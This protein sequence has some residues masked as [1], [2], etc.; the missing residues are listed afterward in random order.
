MTGKTVSPSPLPPP[1]KVIST[2]SG[3]GGSSLGY[4]LA[5]CKVLVACEFVELAAKNYRLN[6]PDTNVVE[7]DIRQVSGDF[8]MK[9]GG[10]VRGELDI[11]D[12]SPP[13]DCFSVSGKRQESWGKFHNYANRKRYAQRTDNLIDE[14]IRLV[15]EIYPKTFVIENV[16]GLTM[17]VSKSLLTWYVNSLRKLG[18]DVQ[19]ELLRASY[20]DTATSRIRLFLIG[21]R[22]DLGIKASHPK[23]QTREKTI[24]EV[25]P[26]VSNT[27]EQLEEA[28]F[29]LMRS[30]R[31]GKIASRLKQGQ[32]GDDVHPSGTSWFNISR[33]SMTKPMTTLTTS[34]HNLIHPIESRSFTIP[35]LQALSS[36][37]PDF[38]FLGTYYEQNERIANAVPPNLMKAIALHVCGI[39]NKSKHGKEE[40]K[41]QIQI[42]K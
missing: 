9:Q 3:V 23:P 19:G 6:F 32:R 17:D 15:S 29:L 11:L 40:D 30:P 1:P 20:Y 21:I 2:F 25:L 26:T 33:Q 24:G 16:K 8:L 27:P 35:E 28:R 38:K 12:G 41:E 36:F 5:G 22:N 37:P 10:V 39:L 42:K 31:S 18:Y 13:C 4:K 34:P 14:Q 7:L